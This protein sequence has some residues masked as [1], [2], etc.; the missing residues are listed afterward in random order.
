MVDVFHLNSSLAL[1]SLPGRKDLRARFGRQNSN[2]GAENP[3][4]KSTFKG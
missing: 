1:F 3:T 4:E 2:P